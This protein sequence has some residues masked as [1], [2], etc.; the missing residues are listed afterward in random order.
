MTASGAVERGRAAFAQRAWGDAYRQFSAADRDAPLAPEDLE[1]LAVA[2]HLIGRETESAEIWTR[3]HHEFL[4]RDKVEHA[5]RCAFWLALFS[6]L[7]QGEP[8]ISSGWIER[9]RRLLGEGHRDCAEQGYL[10]AVAALRAMWEG[11]AAGAHADFTRAATIGERFSDRDLVVFGRLGQ[12][13]TLL[14]LERI[15]KGM[16]LFDEIMVAVTAEEVS[17]LAVGIVYCGVIDACQ[18]IFDIRR[19]QAWTAALSRWCGSQS[20]LVPYRGQCLV[21]RAEIM[22]LHGDWR[23]ALAEAQ[24]AGERSPAGRGRPWVGAACYQQGELYRLRGEFAKAEEAYR[25]ANRWGKE[26]EPGLALLRLAQGRVEAAAAASRRALVE[27]QDGLI[28]ARLL[29]AHVE[30]MLASG[31]IPAA[32]ASSAEVSAIAAAFAAPLLIAAADQAQG[33]VLLAEDDAA[34]ALPA[35]RRAWIALQGLE[36]PYEAARTR[37]LIGLACR[38][39]GDEDSASL[40]LDAAGQ[41]FRR[42]GAAP[43]L[44]RVEALSRGTAAAGGRL[45]AREVEVLRLVADGM[46]NRE[47]AMTLVLSDHTVR[48]HLQNIFAKLGVPSRAAATAFALQHGLI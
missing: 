15:D 19:A 48:R 7:M 6:L 5:A 13:Q 46:T 4:S 12:G 20:D 36:A 41:E 38:A 30:I 47:I 16:A 11:D 10:L 8:V 27:A 40:E 18:A 42:L 39:L 23:D 29:A 24:R 32:R 3:A 35:L 37:V 14:R 22:Q 21:H 31:D 25:E 26:P 2:A 17:P 28:R 1:Q 45:T 34:A 43:D 44:A 33:A 9:G